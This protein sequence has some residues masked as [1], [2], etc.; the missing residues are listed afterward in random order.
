MNKDSN[1][2]NLGVLAGK[3][4]GKEKR[5]GRFFKVTNKVKATAIAAII[6]F[7]ATWFGLDFDKQTETLINALVPV[8]AGYLWK[9]DWDAK[10]KRKIWVAA[11][12]AILTY[13]AFRLQIN[14]SKPVENFI[15]ALV[16]VLVA[17]AIPQE[18]GVEEPPEDDN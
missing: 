2:A 12:L 9:E 7:L 1:T 18:Q 14:L 11:V 13:A 8:L 15:N 10:P 3:F 17:W 6:T 5:M 16:P 4:S